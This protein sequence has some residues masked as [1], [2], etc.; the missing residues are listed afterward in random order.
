MT[1]TQTK[2]TL[3][4]ILE[5]ADWRDEEAVTLFWENDSYYWEDESVEDFLD[6]FDEC[7]QGDYGSATDYA[8]EFVASCGYL[9]DVPDEVARYFDYESFAR[10]MV[11]GGDIWEERG[12]IF[13]NH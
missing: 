1:E 4:A 9:S 3:E 8:E 12:H 7:Y 5:Q 13:T 11:L 2:T 6:R 10:D